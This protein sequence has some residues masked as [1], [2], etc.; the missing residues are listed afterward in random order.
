M[1]TIVSDY[2]YIR[3]LVKF[4]SWYFSFFTQVDNLLLARDRCVRTSLRLLST[5]RFFPSSLYRGHPMTIRLIDSLT[6]HTSHLTAIFSIMYNVRTREY[7]DLILVIVVCSL[8]CGYVFE[9]HK[10]AVHLWSELKLLN[11]YITGIINTMA[12]AN[13]CYNHCLCVTVKSR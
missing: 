2:L 6:S 13:S 9:S 11:Y 3:W 12:C 8:H 10:L 7:V 4:R 5:L 1:T